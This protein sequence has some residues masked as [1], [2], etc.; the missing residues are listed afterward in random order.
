MSSKKTDSKNLSVFISYRRKGISQIVAPTLAKRL[1]EDYDYTVFYDGTELVPKAGVE[2]QKLIFERARGC[3]VLIVLLEKETADSDWVQREVDVARGAGVS[4]LPIPVDVIDKTDVMDKLAIDALQWFEFDSSAPD[5]QSLAIRIEDLA[6]ITRSTQKTWYESMQRRRVLRAPQ[7]IKSYAQFGFKNMS[8]MPTLH[9]AIG[10]MTEMDEIDVLVNSENNYL[11]M[12]RVF[13]HR[14]LSSVLRYKG[15]HVMHGRILEDTVQQELDTYL[16]YANLL[17]PPVPL[18][19][20]IPTHAGHQQSLLVKNGAR[21]IFHVVAMGVSPDSDEVQPVTTDRQF[22][23]CVI[24]ALNQVIEVNKNLGVIAPERDKKR[25]K[26]EVANSASYQPIKSIIFP[27]FGAGHGARPVS[28]VVPHM[29]NG[30]RKFYQDNQY[31][32]A[33]H[34]TD[35]YLCIYN[36]L[37]KETVLKEFEAIFE[38]L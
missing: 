29:L 17:K 2:W 38:R 1:K 5:Y 36:M 35:I 11:Q 4:L 33:L 18:L 9:L 16:Q 31:N 37:E 22:I 15:S 3:D 7:N 14:T 19:E 25:Y 27:L 13:E 23:G 12:A 26:A 21:Y 24:K 20:V 30:F 8:Q 34:L 6:R 10:D 32:T 28:E